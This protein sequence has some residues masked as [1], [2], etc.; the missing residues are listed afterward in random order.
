MSQIDRIYI[1]N[2]W[3]TNLTPSNN[4]AKAEEHAK[5][6][7]HCNLKTHQ[8][9][10]ATS[11]NILLIA[12]MQTDGIKFLTM[13][14]MCVVGITYII[15]RINLASSLKKNQFITFC[16]NTTLLNLSLILENVKPISYD[17]FFVWMKKTNYQWLKLKRW[18]KCKQQ[19]IRGGKIL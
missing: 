13:F 6:W 15:C 11:F 12:R 3:Q 17:S 5:S 1:E 10:L 9:H 4:D 7:K 16:L 14:P 8:H 18:K 2:N 19:I